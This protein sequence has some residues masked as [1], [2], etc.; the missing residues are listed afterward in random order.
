MGERRVVEQTYYE[1]LEVKPNAGATEIY[2]AYQRARS[3]Y[4]PSSPAL[5]SMFTPEEA[6][7]LLALIEEAYQVLSH[8]ARRKEYDVKLGLKTVTPLR[9]T[10]EEAPTQYSAE[11]AR[12]KVEDAWVG[13]VKTAPGPRKNENLPDGYAKTR[14]GV[15]EVK[16]ELEKEIEAIQEC[17][18]EFLRKIREYRGVS[19]EQI[20]EEIRITKTTLAALE[21]NDLGVLPVAVFTRGFVVNF[22]RAL[23]LNEKKITDAYMKFFKAKKSES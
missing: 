15:Y 13:P 22:C 12:K 8:Q 18:G 9:S 5:Y 3:T 1:I 10:K 2:N 11:V 19:V 6:K 17:D 7:Q 23:G 21:T 14:F 20:S 4:S 16:P